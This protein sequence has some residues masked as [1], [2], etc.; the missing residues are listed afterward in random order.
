MR[1]IRRGNS[2]IQ[3]NFAKYED[4]K[5]DLVSRLGIYCSYCERKIN[6]LLAVEHIEPKDGAFGKPQLQCVWTNFLLACINCNSCKGTKQVV[7][8]DILLPDRDN[9]YY[10]YEYKDDG[11]IE[12]RGTLSNAIKLKAE[13]TLALVGL[14]KA[15]T[16][17]L[18]ENKQQVALDRVSQRMQMIAN[19]K[20]SLLLYEE[21]P[22]PNMLKMVIKQA[23]A[24]GFFSI[25]MKVFDAHP[26]VKIELI[27][28]FNGVEV[29]GCFDMTTASTI[30]PCPNSDQLPFG[31]KI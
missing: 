31:G 23:L 28:A 30:T 24:D 18:D 25:W 26:A 27:R 6:T 17:S 21:A 10:A 8:Q 29:S 4:A 2:P 3:G 16:K 20:D 19:A 12:V 22:I 14:D 11:V 5:N 13:S 7:I 9:T 15:Q 1:T